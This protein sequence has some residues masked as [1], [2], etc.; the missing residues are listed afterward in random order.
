LSWVFLDSAD[1]PSLSGLDSKQ[2]PSEN[3]KQK[4]PKSVLDARF[5]FL[6]QNIAICDIVISAF[7]YCKLQCQK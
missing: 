5:R 4:G 3:D 1:A 6:L 7:R 2:I